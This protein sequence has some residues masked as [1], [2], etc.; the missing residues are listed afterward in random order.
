MVRQVDLEGRNHGANAERKRRGWTI[1]VREVPAEVSLCEGN[2]GL[3]A[4]SQGHAVD[5]SA[6]P[7]TETGVE[8]TRHAVRTGDAVGETEE[9]TERNV[10]EQY[11]I[12][13]I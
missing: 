7:G 3:E 8:I 5:V 11:Y 9:Q 2:R 13:D 6:R 12:L 1:R 4:D 10:T